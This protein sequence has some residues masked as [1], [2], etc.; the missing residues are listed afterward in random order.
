M[1]FCFT[2]GVLFNGKLRDTMVALATGNLEI[3]DIV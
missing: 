2:L 1:L 3:D